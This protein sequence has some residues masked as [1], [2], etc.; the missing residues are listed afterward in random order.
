MD[1]L[2]K[3]QV[4]ITPDKCYKFIKGQNFRFEEI[5]TKNL[6]WVPNE[7]FNEFMRFEIVRGNIVSSLDTRDFQFVE[8][9][10]EILCAIEQH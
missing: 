8:E 9:V 6:D 10:S 1:R 2:L 3:K 4:K 5:D 7:Q